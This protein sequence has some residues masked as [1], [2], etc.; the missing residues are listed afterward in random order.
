M[1]TTRYPLKD[2]KTNPQFEF[3]VRDIMRMD[4][5]L[6]SNFDEA[7]TKAKTLSTPNRHIAVYEKYFNTVTREW[8]SLN[9]FDAVDGELRYDRHARPDLHLEFY[10]N[11]GEWMNPRQDWLSLD[12][13]ETIE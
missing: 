13:W 4:Y 9:T 8:H 3:L 11:A 7:I 1:K 10:V 6:F 2:K 5:W 12:T